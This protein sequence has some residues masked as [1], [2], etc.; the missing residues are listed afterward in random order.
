MIPRITADTNEY[1]T[2]YTPGGTYLEGYYEG[3]EVGYFNTSIRSGYTTNPIVLIGRSPWRDPSSYRRFIRRF[4]IKSSKQLLYGWLPRW[5]PP[6]NEGSG[7]V[8][9]TDVP[10]YWYNQSVIYDENLKN[11]ANTKALLKIAGNKAQLGVALAESKKAFQ[12]LANTTV[13]LWTAYRHARRGE[14]KAVERSLGLSGSGK[15]LSGLYPANKWLEYQYGW[16]P[17]LSDLHDLYGVVRG[18]LEQDSFLIHGKGGAYRTNDFDFTSF[19]SAARAS[20]RHRSKAEQI[21]VTRLTGQLS[22]TKWRQASQIGLINPLSIGWELVPFSF[23]LDWFM[24]I[25]NVLEAL[26]ARAG[27][28]FVGGSQTWITGGKSR[29]NHVSPWDHF[30]VYGESE[31]KL[32]D[33]TRAKLQMWP[34]PLPYVVESPFNTKRTANALALWRATLRGRTPDNVP[35]YNTRRLRRQF[36]V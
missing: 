35:R 24:P 11:Q 23:L 31:L 18:S 21:V 28:D 2:A 8:L 12:M 34:L 1:G 5:L 26:T 25:G 7:I 9:A 19:D 32:F 29:V 27:L 33:L 4:K 36:R 6:G 22:S 15:V 17:L 16:K 13:S 10:G 20:L 14:W 3:Y 30:E